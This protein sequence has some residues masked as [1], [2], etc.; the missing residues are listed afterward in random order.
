M[1]NIHHVDLNHPFNNKFTNNIQSIT[2]RTSNNYYTIIL[3]YT[4][5]HNYT[6]TTININSNYTTN[7]NHINNETNKYSN[8]LT[9]NHYITMIIINKSLNKGLS[10][11]ITKNTIINNNSITLLNLE[12][13]HITTPY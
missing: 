5:I 4:R 7:S 9:H 10:I 3:Y 11:N 6:L 1:M 2:I 8:L 13:A 12:G